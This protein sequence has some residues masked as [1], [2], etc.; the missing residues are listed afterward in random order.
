MDERRHFNPAFGEGVWRL[1]RGPQDR[2]RLSKGRK[3]SRRRSN[4]RYCMTYYKPDWDGQTAAAGITA[5][6]TP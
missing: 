2:A 5:L 6:T 1:L 4:G 3:D